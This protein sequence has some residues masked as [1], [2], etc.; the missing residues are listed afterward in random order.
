MISKTKRAAAL[1]RD[2][3]GAIEGLPLQL[4]ILVIIAG[5]ATTV[6]VGWMGAIDMPKGIGSVQVEPGQIVLEDGEGG[7]RYAEGISLDV[8]VL[9]NMGEP[10][11]GATV[12]LTGCSVKDGDL[13]VVFAITGD[14]GI[15]RFNSL[16]MQ[17]SGGVGFLE[18]SASKSG[19]SSGT[20][21]RVL[22]I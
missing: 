10:V 22:V 20:D 6:I 16:S 12:V 15:A 13:P 17:T 7:I 9:D 5:L 21:A 11:Q 4:M 3:G 8:T 1:Q 19:Y 18:V 14:D 2:R